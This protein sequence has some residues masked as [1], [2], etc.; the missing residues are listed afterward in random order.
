[1]IP[2][3]VEDDDILTESNYSAWALSTQW[4]L[5]AKGEKGKKLWHLVTRDAA[6][7]EADADDDQ[8]ATPSMLP[9]ALGSRCSFKFAKKLRNFEFRA[10]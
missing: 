3:P 2:T 10:I 1:M 9:L 8:W 6:L 4:A 5:L 7:D